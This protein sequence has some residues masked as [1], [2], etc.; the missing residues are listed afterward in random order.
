VSC[1]GLHAAQPLL[2][3][4]LALGV[5]EWECAFRIPSDQEELPRRHPTFNEIEHICVE[6]RE[7]RDQGHEEA[8]WNHQV[9]MR[10]LEFILKEQ[11]TECDDFRVIG[12]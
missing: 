2:T 12:W 4:L 1:A 7:C 8:A 10:L 3:L 11:Y 5:D 6:A 9:H